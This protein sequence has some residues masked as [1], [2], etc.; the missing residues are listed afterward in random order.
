MAGSDDQ[1]EGR[2]LIAN[3]LYWLQHTDRW[4]RECTAQLDAQEPQV[5]QYVEQIVQL[6]RQFA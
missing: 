3:L 2:K 1:F 6:K 4:H 5:R